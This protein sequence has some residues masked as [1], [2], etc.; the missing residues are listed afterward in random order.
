MKKNKYLLKLII[1]TFIMASCLHASDHS[2][3]S[4]TLINIPTHIVQIHIVGHW[5]KEGMREK[6]VREFVNE[7]EFVNQEIRVNMKFPEEL[8]KDDTG[9]FE[10]I[11]NQVTK[12]VADFDII[13][14]KTDYPV[15]ARMMKNE[16]WGS[17]YLVNFIDVPGF[18]DR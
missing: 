6:L 2:I 16:N 4:G 18:L 11:I 12:P 13:R 3:V 14:L 8:Y 7:F 9:E 17:Q 10:F 1:V 5:L 15:I